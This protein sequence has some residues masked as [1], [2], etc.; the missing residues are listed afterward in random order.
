VIFIENVA[1]LRNGLSFERPTWCFLIF[2]TS[3]EVQSS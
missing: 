2:L 3:T 1:G